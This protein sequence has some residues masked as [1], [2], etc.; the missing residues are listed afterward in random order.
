[1]LRAAALALAFVALPACAPAPVQEPRPPSAPSDASA[2]I[3]G[4]LDD[5]HDAAAKADFARYFG[6]LSEDSVFLGTDATERWTKPEFS[7]YAKP[8]FDKG[9]AWS[10]RAKRR[11][12][13]VAPGGS[14]AWFDEDLETKGLGPARG[15]GV[16]V[17][18]DGLWQIA[19]YNLTITIP[20]ER[21]GL[22][23]EA[24]GS[25]EVLAAKAADPAARLAW[26]A[27]AWVGTTDKGEHVEEQW[28]A[29]G[30]STM[31]GSGRSTKDDKTV[32]FE[33]LRVVVKDGKLVYVA[34]PLG[35]PPTEFVEAAG[36]AGEIVFENKAHDWPKRISYK[37]TS[38]GLSVRVE[39]DAGQ[40]A[41]AWMMKPA[42]VARGELPK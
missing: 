25:A 28:L 24:A 42:V 36:A 7:A 1:M 13:I 18:R 21:F 11:S 33:H 29:P 10:F 6:H 12:V 19:H 38:D 34:Q 14:L 2:K 37:R 16:V 22:A 32:F 4:V 20:N 30:G 39:G 15:S 23:K 9:K 5:W 35:K 31:I 27:G 41:E 26:L 17:E 3:A 40:P 8:H